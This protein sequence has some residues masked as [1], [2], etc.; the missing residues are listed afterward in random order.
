MFLY[1][2]ADDKMVDKCVAAMDD[3]ESTRNTVGDTQV[4]EIICTTISAHSNESSGGVVEDLE[5]EIKVLRGVVATL[6]KKLY[7][8][9]LIRTESVKDILS[10]GGYHI[11]R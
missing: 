4:G 2:A 9:K 10:A 1:Q 8:A 3:P 11:G 5:D 6:I 7:G